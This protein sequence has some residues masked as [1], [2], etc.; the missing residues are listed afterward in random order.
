MN[1]SRSDFS[2]NEDKD[3]T[4]SNIPMRTKRDREQKESRKVFDQRALL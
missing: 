1:R 2:G 3:Q 4:A